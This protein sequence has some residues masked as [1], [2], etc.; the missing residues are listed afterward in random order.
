MVYKSKSGIIFKKCE[1]CNKELNEREKSFC[2]IATTQTGVIRA[3]CNNCLD[4]KFNGR[5]PAKTTNRFMGIGVDFYGKKNYNPNDTSYTSIEWFVFIFLPIIPLKAFRIRKI[6]H[7]IA[8]YIIYRR[9]SI[10]YDIIS[11]IPLSANKGLI[12]KTYISVYAFLSLMIGSAILSIYYP[13]FVI[14]PILLVVIYL[15]WYLIKH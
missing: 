13:Q 8:N 5:Y 4:T 10:K 11:Q 6:G 12:I 9:E 7:E 14:V 2:D 15:I 1:F 3:I